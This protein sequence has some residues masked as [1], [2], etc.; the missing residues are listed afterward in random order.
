MTERGILM[1]DGTKN[2]DT[3]V[4]DFS[5]STKEQIR[6]DRM[7]YHEKLMQTIQGTLD[8]MEKLDESE[9]EL[10]DEEDRDLIGKDGQILIA[11][12]AYIQARR[13][14]GLPVHAQLDKLPD[15]HLAGQIVIR[16]TSVYHAILTS[17]DS[18]YIETIKLELDRRLVP[19]QQS[20]FT[21]QQYLDR[22]PFLLEQT[23]PD[24][25]EIDLIQKY[26]TDAGIASV[27]K[28]NPSLPKFFSEFVMLISCQP[29][30]AKRVMES[31]LNPLLTSRKGIIPV[32]RRVSIEIALLCAQV[33]MMKEA[34]DVWKKVY[35][36]GPIDK[37]DNHHQGIEL[38]LILAR[39]KAPHDP[40]AAKLYFFHARYLTL[41]SGC[42]DAK[43]ASRFIEVALLLENPRW[44]LDQISN[45]TFNDKPG[46]WTPTFHQKL[47]EAYRA[48]ALETKAQKHLLAI[49]HQISDLYTRQQSF[50]RKHNEVFWQIALS[51]VERIDGKDP[52]PGLVRYMHRVIQQMEYVKDVAPFDASSHFNG[53]MRF[54]DGMIAFHVDPTPLLSQLKVFISQD[55]VDAQFWR[56]RTHQHLTEILVREIAWAKV[57]TDHDQRSPIKSMSS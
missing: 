15:P 42:D 9:E 43:L 7:A 56:G 30:R 8:I 25:Q 47:F 10:D 36:I 26:F 57:Q 24:S 41:K 23:D 39:E 17:C 28:D 12:C 54:V 31:I 19:A 2:L 38:V 32:S 40:E 35:Q 16:D 3:P 45:Q 34:E 22:L 51:H 1:D 44:A 55:M 49:Q 53:W 27:T 18:N 37:L 4:E 52:R 46:D 11:R 13:A 14:L 48:M 20:A 33:N 6:A 50:S 21:K 5:L 29:E